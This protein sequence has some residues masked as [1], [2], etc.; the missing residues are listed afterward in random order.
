[1]HKNPWPKSPKALSGQ[2]LFTATLQRHLGIKL[3]E[4]KKKKKKQQCFYVTMIPFAV[5]QWTVGTCMFY[6]N[7]QAISFVFETRLLN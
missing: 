7:I 3:K 1:M 4:G 2:G 5:K 6:T